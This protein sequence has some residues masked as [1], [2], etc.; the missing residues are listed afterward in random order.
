MFEGGVKCLLIEVEFQ[1]ISIEISS[2]QKINYTLIYSD[3]DSPMK[4]DQR[5]ELAR[6]INRG[7]HAKDNP[8][9][10][11]FLIVYKDLPADPGNPFCIT[12]QN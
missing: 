2:D 3:P 5:F 12:D 6:K 8:I 10:K 4:Y 1:A 7:I 11:L 9:E